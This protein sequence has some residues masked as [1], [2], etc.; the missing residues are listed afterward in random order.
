MGLGTLDERMIIL[1]DIE[2]LMT[3]ND[4]ALVEAAAA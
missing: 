1:A 3:S 2:R 4:M